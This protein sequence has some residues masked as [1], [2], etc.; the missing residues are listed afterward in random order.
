LRTRALLYT[1]GGTG[2]ALVSMMGMISAGAQAMKETI[3]GIAGVAG[4]F[5]FFILLTGLLIFPF[6]LRHWKQMKKS[7]GSRVPPQ[8]GQ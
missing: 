4:L 6:A 7:T 2:L 3:I 5:V 1:F 8:P